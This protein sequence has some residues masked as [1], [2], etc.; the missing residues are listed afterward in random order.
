MISYSGFRLRDTVSRV[1]PAAL[2]LIFLIYEYSNIIFQEPQLNGTVLIFLI[3]ILS[4]PIGLISE[5][6]AL[7]IV[8][9]LVKPTKRLS[10]AALI[11]KYLNCTVKGF[12]NRYIKIYST[13]K[14]ELLNILDHYNLVRFFF[15]NMS[16]LFLLALIFHS[17]HSRVVFDSINIVLAPFVVLFINYYFT[18]QEAY[19]Y[20]AGTINKTINGDETFNE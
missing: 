1:I 13:G 3:V 5:V 12:W 19:Y 2:F 10:D 20:V 6:L 11:K 7:N 18:H 15:L 9:F 8:H 4:Y 17:V 16:F 14:P